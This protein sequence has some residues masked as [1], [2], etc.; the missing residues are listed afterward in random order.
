MITMTGY[1]N[2]CICSEELPLNEITDTLRIKPTKQYKKGDTHYDKI[3]ENTITYTMDRWV[4]DKRIETEHLEHE[5]LTFISLFA[6]N[7]AYIKSLAKRFEVQFW[8]S[9][10]PES[11]QYYI[12]LP[13]SVIEAVYKLGV[14]IGIE[15][16][17]LRAFYDGT[18]ISKKK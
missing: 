3:T 13:H 1:L 7:A 8:L 5:M 12:H 2:L 17:D 15:V 4:L 16:A 6:G 10:Y 11:E 18:Y 9:I 14:S